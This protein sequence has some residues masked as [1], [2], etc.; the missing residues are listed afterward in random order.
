MA[1]FDEM[2]MAQT[3]SATPFTVYIMQTAHTDIGYTHPQEQ[4]ALMYLEHYDRV[5]ELC[6]QTEQAPEAQ[7]F[8]WTCETFWQVRH[9]LT[10]RPEREADFLHFAR[11]GQIE[12]M[13]GYLHF[14]DLI[15]A[16]AY[17]RSIQIAVDYCRAHDLPLRCLLHAD[18]NGWPWAIADILA[19]FGIPY[20]M[21]HVHI[22][23]GTDP[24][25]KRG[26]VHYAW[27][28]EWGDALRPDVPVRMP[29]AFW[30]QGPQ[31]GKVLHFLNEH[32]HLGNVLGLSSNHP[33]GADKTRYFLETDRKTAG[34]L[35][36]I[37][38]QEVPRYIQRLRDEGYP[39]D[40]LLINT[41]GFYVDNS[42]PDDRWL[43]IIARWNSEHDDIHLRSA[44]PSEWLDH[45]LTL[46]GGDWPARQVAWPDH[47][48]HGLGSMTANMAQVRR[49]Q[50]RRA[51]AIAVV[52]AAHSKPAEQALDVAL[53]QE[54]LAL[55]HT[56]CAWST[57]AWPAAP[58]NQFQQIVKELTF[59]RAEM[60]YDE[61][62]GKGL[63]KLT[64]R[65]SD[66]EQRLYAFAE[67]GAA[68]SM[69]SLHF[70]GG[71]MRVDANRHMLESAD[72]QRFAIQRDREDL[73]HFVAVVPLA[74]AGL[75]AFR[76]VARDAAPAHND[77][78]SAAEL[79]S[80][81]WRLSADPATGCL[82]R[83]QDAAGVEW[84]DARHGYGFGQMVH[85]VVVHPLGRAATSNVGRLIALGAVAEAWRERWADVPV[86]ER[87]TPS[88]V[89]WLGVSRG[90]VFD[91]IR[92]DVAGKRLGRARV[93]W[94]VYHA[95]PI[96][97]QVIEWEKP[98]C[99]LPEAA[100]VAFPFNPNAK[101]LALETAGGF[102][103]PGSH[104]AGGQLPGTCSSYYTV[105]RAA[106]IAHEGASLLWLPVDAPLVMLNEI[107]YN[108]WET[109]PFAWNGLLASMPV[110]HY[111]HTN[112][113]TSQ[114]G[115]LQ[116][117]Y[118]FAS[119]GR[120]GDAIGAALPLSALGWR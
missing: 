32:Y 90:E 19:E 70:T 120:A 51:S 13:A 38:L 49:T 89:E 68:G 107:D 43:Q 108:R 62:I 86:Y 74:Q 20:F 40:S 87:S 92:F 39:Y 8:K 7:R 66:G 78:V 64:S 82:T 25:G 112:F 93:A 85:E 106:R 60:H 6:R 3:Q 53:E 76:L 47:W 114:R 94:R 24:L 72:G 61:A 96:V 91:A 21:S 37:A 115:K 110:N 119:D 4:I 95:A 100:Y 52:E 5:L 117:R 84:V 58:V 30:W 113:P 83:L 2:L 57:T 44:T 46:D 35:Y 97:E 28:R 54:R 71:D 33:F 59:H 41:G 63:R 98:W 65:A 26:S 1:I 27:T 118:R 22:D 105:Q 73:P 67:A 80:T 45:L 34:D 36:D 103:T 69:R 12:L 11:N 31:G 101:R 79:S 9:Y 14:T 77:E 116:L 109:E 88:Q 75:N 56:F 17:R 81:G 104:D 102:F 18:I 50:R 111:W 99:D 29:Q 48:A 16:D 23:S 55:E 15:D 42:P 10:H